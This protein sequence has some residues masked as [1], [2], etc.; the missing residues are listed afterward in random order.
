[1]SMYHP[2]PPRGC[3][4]KVGDACYLETGEFETGGGLN[5]WTWLL[6]DGMER[7]IVFSKEQVPPR[8]IVG[9]DPL[10]T[11][12]FETYIAADG[13]SIPIPKGKLAKYEH[14][15]VATKSP[16]VADHVGDQFYSAWSFYRECIQFGPS[17]RVTKQVAKA[18]SE[19]INTVGPVPMIFSHPK[20][21]IFRSEKERAGAMEHVA[22]VLSTEFEFKYLF[23]TWTHD[24][25]GM[26]SRL[27]QWIGKSHF[28][29]PILRTIHSLKDDWQELKEKHKWVT[30]RKL[31]NGLRYTTQTFGCAWLCKVSY[32]LPSGSTEP[33]AEMME[34]P[35]INVIDLKKAGLMAIK[36]VFD[37]VK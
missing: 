28:M 29:L 18:I 15:R 21:P 11:I 3:G 20:I 5:A 7:T 23:P 4:G 37:N 13:P 33:D 35:G 9:I 34:L 30:A 8:Q 24:N 31:F 1:M 32:P 19:I 26:Y 36:E 17:R 12:L 2:D 14:L 6:G 22:A 27:D 10:M 25:W 16:G